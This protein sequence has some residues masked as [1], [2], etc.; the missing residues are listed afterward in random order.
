MS[1]AS[2][3]R[4]TEG[5]PLVG[6]QCGCREPGRRTEQVELTKV[7]AGNSQSTISV[8]GELYRGCDRA[9]MNI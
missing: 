9:A 3:G 5:V 1:R 8:W 4:I 2:L 6:Q 7:P